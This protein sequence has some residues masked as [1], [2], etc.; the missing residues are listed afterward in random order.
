MSLK[1]FHILFITLSSVMSI[2]VGVWALD[3]YGEDGSAMWLGLAVLAIGGSVGLVFY[4]TR[5]LH[6]MRKL[7][8]AMFVVAGTLAAPGDVLACAVC[9][10]NTH[11][12]LRDGMNMGILALLGFTSFMLVSFASFF[13]YL[14]RR[15]RITNH[16]SEIMNPQGSL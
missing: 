14:A 15:A 9:L 6:K 12:P 2:V 8:I 13:I 1:F 7:G 10:G 5:F 16:E 3:A 11:S 4:G